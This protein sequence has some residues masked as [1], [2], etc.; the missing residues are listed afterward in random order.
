MATA[1]D[2]PR[3]GLP[4]VLRGL[5]NLGNTCFMNSVLQVG[6]QCHTC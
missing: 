6:E 4:L 3:D 1:I 5:N 2:T